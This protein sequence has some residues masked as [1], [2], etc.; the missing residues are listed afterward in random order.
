MILTAE[1]LGS[2]QLGVVPNVL[3]HAQLLDSTPNVED[4]HEVEFG[5]ELSVIAVQQYASV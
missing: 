1:A 2:Q 4:S 5:N 3:R